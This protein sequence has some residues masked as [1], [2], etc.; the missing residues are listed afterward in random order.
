MMPSYHTQK[1]RLNLLFDDSKHRVG[2]ATSIQALDSEGNIKAEFDR[3]AA[4]TKYSF[5]N[6]FGTRNDSDT[7]GEGICVV[8]ATTYAEAANKISN[9]PLLAVPY[10]LNVAR[11]DASE[12]EQVL[13][14]F[15]RYNPDTMDI[16]GFDMKALSLH[17]TSLFVDHLAEEPGNEIQEYVNGSCL[18]FRSNTHYCW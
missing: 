18:P 14:R 2:L 3:F 11:K 8:R 17:V 6:G 4:I 5:E 16:E 12:K 7:F 15:L 9:D 1:Y 13:K 10:L